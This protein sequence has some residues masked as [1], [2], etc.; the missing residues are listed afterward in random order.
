MLLCFD[1]RVI[2]AD[3]DVL[4][5]VSEGLAK[6][7]KTAYMGCVIVHTHAEAD[8]ASIIQIKA[9]NGHIRDLQTVDEGSFLVDDKEF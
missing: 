5:V 6:N 1:G 8:A 4:S 7:R 2:Q 3:L 9:V